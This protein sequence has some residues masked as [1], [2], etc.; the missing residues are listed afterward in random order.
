MSPTNRGNQIS[1]KDM[2]V[3]VDRIS[4]AQPDFGPPEQPGWQE[5]GAKGGVHHCE[6]KKFE[7]SKPFVCHNLHFDESA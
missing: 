2:D 1:K 3:I 6:K 7:C 4:K 5:C